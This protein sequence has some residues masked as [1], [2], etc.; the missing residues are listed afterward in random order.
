MVASVVRLHA[1]ET[2]D[3]AMTFPLTKRMCR[4]VCVWYCVKHLKDPQK[5]T[6]WT[7]IVCDCDGELQSAVFA[8]DVRVSVAHSVCERVC[9]AYVFV[10]IECL[11]KAQHSFT[12]Y[13]L[14]VQTRN[15]RSH[16]KCVSVCV[17]FCTHNTTQ[18]G[19]VGIQ[20]RIRAHLRACVHECVLLRVYVRVLMIV[21]RTAAR[22]SRCME[23]EISFD[24]CQRLSANACILCERALNSRRACVYVC[25]CLLC[26]PHRSNL[27]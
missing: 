13:A 16:E 21:W 15:R 18:L 10:F 26:A 2:T 3:R 7:I 9:I 19:F 24:N 23:C 22:F 17:S 6:Y 12:N 1:M 4:S 11:N 20:V 5:P 25:E 27:H 14:C 8:N